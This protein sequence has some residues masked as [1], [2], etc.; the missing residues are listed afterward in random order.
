MGRYSLPKRN[1]CAKHLHWFKLQRGK[2]FMGAN[3]LKYFMPLLY[4][5]GC[6]C[7]KQL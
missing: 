3:G 5:H 4:A 2:K 6:K 1:K 7:F